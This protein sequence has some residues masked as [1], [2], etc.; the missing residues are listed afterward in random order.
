MAIGETPEQTR[1]RLIER[2]DKRF[3]RDVNS[4]VDPQ[5]PTQGTPA[6]RSRDPIESTRGIGYARDTGGGGGG[7]FTEANADERSFYDEVSVESSDGLLTLNIR[8]IEQVIMTAGDGGV[9]EFNYDNP[10]E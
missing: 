8:P 2:T 9:T 1:Q 6:N 5:E 7:P 4:L 3:V 10:F